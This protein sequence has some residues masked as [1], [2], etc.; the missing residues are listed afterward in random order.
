MTFYY[1]NKDFYSKTAKIAIFTL[2]VLIPG[3]MFAIL[4]V[5][6]AIVKLIEMDEPPTLVPAQS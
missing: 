6:N 2:M 4:T 5:S 1:L 3:A